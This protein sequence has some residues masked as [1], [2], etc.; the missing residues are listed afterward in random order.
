ES[1]LRPLVSAFC[2]QPRGL[3]LDVLQRVQMVGLALAQ[4]PISFGLGFVDMPA[5]LLRILLQPLQLPRSLPHPPDDLLSLG[6]ASAVE[7]AQL[8][9]VGGSGPLLERIGQR[10]EPWQVAL[11]C[12]F[13]LAAGIGKALTMP[14]CDLVQDGLDTAGVRGGCRRVL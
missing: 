1:V 10:V 12:C 4:P 14:R 7:G 9:G 5:R 2:E 6:L 11:P 8:A 3:V 13:A